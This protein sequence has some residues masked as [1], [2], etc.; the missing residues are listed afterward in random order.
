MESLKRF[1]TFVKESWQEVRYQ[2][3]YPS[4]Q[5]V[6]GTWKVVMATTAFFALLLFA[7]DWVMAKGISEIFKQFA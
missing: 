2:V 3:T 5:E 4:K 7:I 1:I 6:I